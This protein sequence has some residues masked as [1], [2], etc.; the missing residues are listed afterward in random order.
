[1]KAHEFSHSHGV[2]QATF[3]PLAIKKATWTFILRIFE[4]CSLPLNR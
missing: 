1:M 2:I 4:T 3:K